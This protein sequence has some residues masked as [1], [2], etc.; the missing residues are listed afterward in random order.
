MDMSSVITGKQK[1]AAVF[2]I[3]QRELAG[4]VSSVGRSAPSVEPVFFF[5]T[6]FFH[7]TKELED[8]GSG[9]KLRPSAF[10]SG[11]A[12]FQCSLSTPTQFGT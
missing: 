6:F 3:L 1:E 12:K 4:P 8:Q 11:F 7:K 5:F 2:R 9:W 10:L